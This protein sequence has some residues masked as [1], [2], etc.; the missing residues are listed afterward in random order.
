MNTVTIRSIKITWKEHSSNLL[1]N[2]EHRCSTVG[3]SICTMLRMKSETSPVVS[4]ITDFGPEGN[5]RITL[6]KWAVK[7]KL[8]PSSRVIVSE[9]MSN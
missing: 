9:F 6:M 3:D 8:N 2:I 1:F 5:P 4:V 7:V